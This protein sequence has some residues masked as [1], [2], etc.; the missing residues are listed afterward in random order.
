MFLRKYV[1]VSWV[2]E[3]NVCFP[4]F[5]IFVMILL[6]ERNTQSFINMKE[7]SGQTRKNALS[8]EI[9]WD[10]LLHFGQKTFK[11]CALLLRAI[12]NTLLRKRRIFRNQ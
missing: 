12:G 1:K 6:K 3:V 11:F 7:S 10:D 2:F 4:I 9:M 5:T 8:G